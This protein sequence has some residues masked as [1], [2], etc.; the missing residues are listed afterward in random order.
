MSS[1]VLKVTSSDARFANV[2]QN[3]LLLPLTIFSE[4]VLGQVRYWLSGVVLRDVS[5]SHYAMEA[6]VLRRYVIDHPV[7]DII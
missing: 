6:P 5:V 4:K 1:T 2:R 7:D 3:W